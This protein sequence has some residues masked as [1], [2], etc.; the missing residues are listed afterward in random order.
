[1]KKAIV[2]VL[3][4]VSFVLLLVA[5]IMLPPPSVDPHNPDLVRAA[6]WYRVM[7]TMR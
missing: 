4:V 6:S 7:H 5:S 2:Y 1:M 3:I